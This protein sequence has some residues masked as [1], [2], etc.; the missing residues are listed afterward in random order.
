M[1]RR[2]VVSGIVF[3]LAAV[4]VLAAEPTNQVQDAYF[5]GFE[6]D[7][8][9]DYGGRDVVTL[10]SAMSRALGWAIRV[11]RYPAVAASYEL[12][13]AGGLSTV[14]HEVFGHG[15]RAREYGLDPS[16]GFGLDFSGS[17][18]IGKDPESN[19]Q[20]IMLTAGGTEGDSV[21]ANRIL[22]S[23]YTGGGADGSRI[24]LMA[25]A[26]V[27]FS[28]YCLF[29]PDPQN[30]R[31]DFVDAYTNGNDIAYYLTAR[32]AQR[33]GGDPAAV[34]NNDYAVDFNDPL[35]AKNYDDVRAAAIWN[36]ID[37]AGLAAVY[38]YVTDHLARGRTQ[39]KPPVIPF[40]GG[41]GLTAG[42][43]A[44][45]GPE[46]VTRF[47]DLYVVTP[48]PLIALYGRDLQS[49]VDSSYGG[50]AGVYGLRVARG[51]T[52]SVSGDY[53]QVPESVEGLYDGSGWNVC[54][55]IEALVAGRAGVTCKVG[56]KSEGF[57]PGTPMDSGLYAGAGLLVSF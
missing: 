15:S 51:I 28:L 24:P 13:L 23:L 48:G 52:F 4:G 56:A 32:Q 37:P 1:R 43:R 44:F 39:V 35:L 26:K 7:P 50:G 54:G 18:S 5:L 36:L 38:G 22:R 6:V 45:L 25:L 34:W 20:N 21:M 9:M 16:Y 19:E 14:Q 27:D 47:L 49:S 11:D 30:N 31:D 42:T 17:T 8:A 53:W 41:Y 3:A 55:E 29:T 10:H 46:E 12:I 40:G 33:T 57:F 2:K